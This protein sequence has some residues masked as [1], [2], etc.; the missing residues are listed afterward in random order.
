MWDEQSFVSLEFVLPLYY[1]VDCKFN[2]TAN[3]MIQTRESNSIQSVVR[4]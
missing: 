3:N 1:G 4:E 2:I